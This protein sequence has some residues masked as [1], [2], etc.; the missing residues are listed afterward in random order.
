MPSAVDGSGR[1]ASSAAEGLSAACRREAGR[2]D[3]VP[4]TSSSASK[5]VR[6]RSFPRARPR[7]ASYPARP[8]YG[9]EQVI[10]LEYPAGAAPAGG[11]RV[12]R[13]PAPSRRGC[14]A[15]AARIRRRTV[16]CTRCWGVDA[17]R[18][19]AARGARRGLPVRG[20]QVDAHHLFVSD[21]TEDIRNARGVTVSIMKR[22]ARWARR[23]MRSS[24]CP[25]SGSPST[26][27]DTRTAGRID[28]GSVDTLVLAHRLASQL[29]V[30][31][32]LQLALQVAP[33]LA[34][35]LASSSPRPP[36]SRAA[37]LG[38]QVQRCRSG[39]PTTSL[40]RP[41]RGEGV[42]SG[43]SVRRWVR[44]ANPPERIRCRSVPAPGGED[45][46]LLLVVLAVPIRLGVS[47]LSGPSFAG[48]RVRG[49][50]VEFCE[51]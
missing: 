40:E 23:S 25:R 33:Q 7:R 8:S 24:G 2:P 5:L 30:Q 1:L 11:C 47:G 35:Q 42:T 19:A 29:A 14:A 38:G 50:R 36:S 18:R 22:G 13:V 9:G 21:E 44:L 28:T 6:K 51:F 31:V 49:S 16:R 37:E 27:V 39:T 20:E 41:L 3:S 46:V 48:A 34:V 10:R 4:P 17:R 15:S 43:R 32:A 26:A 12:H 45:L